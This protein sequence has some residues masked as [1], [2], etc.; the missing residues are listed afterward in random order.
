MDV[1][2]MDSSGNTI[3]QTNNNFGNSKGITI[4][5]NEVA[6]TGYSHSFIWQNINFIYPNNGGDGQYPFI[7]RFNKTTGTIIGNH[8]LTANSVSSDYGQHIL[9]D[10]LGNYL[11][12]GL[13]QSTLNGFGGAITN[14]GGSSD[15]FVAKLGTSNCDFLTTPTF[16][17]KGIFIYP[18]PVQNRLFINSEETQEYEIYSILGTK[19][20]V[21][22]LS[23]GSGIDCSNLTSGVY[24]LS[25]RDGFGKVNTF[26]FVKE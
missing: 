7:I 24:L 2:K 23:V 19:I 22:T 18:N 12:G 3:W 13:F 20:S 5:E 6:I 25:L 8:Y 9:S 1:V 4:N 21:G 16:D 26:K 15:F 11:I 10:N 17:R 14:V